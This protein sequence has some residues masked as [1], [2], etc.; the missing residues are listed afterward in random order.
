LKTI[1]DVKKD[2]SV[3]G[4][5]RVGQS[6]A[7]A[8]HNRGWSC[9]S[10]I[11]RSRVPAIDLARRVNAAVVADDVQR[12]QP[13]SWIFVCTPDDVVPA[14]AASLAGLHIGWRGINLA[15]TSG[16]ISS[17]IFAPVAA[18]GARVSS[19]HPA[20][21][22][23]GA[24]D[25]WKKFHGAIFGIEAPDTALEAVRELVHELGA[26]AVTIPAGQKTA[27]HLA[28]VLASNYLVTLHSLAQQICREST[29]DEARLRTLLVQLSQ[30]TLTSLSAQAPAQVLTGPIMRGDAG[31]VAAHL[32][33]LRSTFPH[34]VEIYVALGKE[35]LKLANLPAA[36]ARNLEGLFKI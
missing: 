33:L 27:Y 31:T 34:L 22:F 12:L 9:N 26:S 29:T 7:M 17:S 28:C 14:V 21:S 13:A 6:F 5:G 11:S 10:V 32:E 19:L 3:I 36:Q 23:S 20:V 35:T 16:S 4:A 8:L 25:D 18:A 30:D 1:I 2:F 24:A 15:H